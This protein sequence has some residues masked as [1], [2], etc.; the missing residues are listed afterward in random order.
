MHEDLHKKYGN[1]VRVNFG[2]KW[3]NM[4]YLY[5]PND[6][7]TM[8]RSEDRYPRR[9]GL[10]ALDFYRKSKPEIYGNGGLS[11]SQGKSWY[12]FRT[13]VQQY[14]MKPNLVANY[15]PTFNKIGNELIE[16]INSIK[17][18]N[19]EVNNFYEYL[20]KFGL[21]AIAIVALEKKLN[22]IKDSDSMPELNQIIKDA[23]TIFDGSFMLDITPFP[24]WRWINRP[25][26]K[27][28]KEYIAASERFEKM[29]IKYI[30]ESI[31]KIE[32]ESTTEEN[33]S[34]LQSLLSRKDFG[35][36]ESILMSLDLLLSGI[37]TTSNTEAFLLY[38]LAKNPEVQEKLYK[39]IKEVVGDCKEVTDSM[40]EQ[41]KYLKAC[42][43]ES[44]RINP[45]VNGTTRTTEHD[46]VLSGYR[47]PKGT[48]LL[49]VN[50]IP[51]RNEKY[52]PEPLQ[53]R[54]ERWLRGNEESNNH[55]FVLMPFGFGPR[56]CIGKRIAEQEIRVLVLKIIQNFKIENKTEDL[57]FYTKLVN[58][59]DKPLKFKFTQRK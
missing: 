36:K 25:F 57:G 43:K 32:S 28:W 47:I 1:I 29:A 54:P 27:L 9:D 5:D 38:N 44:L 16:V 48:V 11:E 8:F 6:I 14:M 34:I 4:L 22:L 17:D 24:V 3:K 33:Q 19:G 12:N 2:T 35:R 39:E 40:I 52:F 46:I 50:Y 15:L 7:E 31:R 30:D 23:N 45:T 59:P 20:Y 41:M 56:M 21:E 51:C 53:Y 10:F 13:K 26:G 58:I 55:P 42:I 37:E 18:V 49:A